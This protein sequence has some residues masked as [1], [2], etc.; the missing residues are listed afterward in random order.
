M[1]PPVDAD[2][3]QL[4]LKK[5]D[6]RRSPTPVIG[7]N[8]FPRRPQNFAGFVKK[9]FR[10]PLPE[11]AVGQPDDRGDRRQ[12]LD[13]LLRRDDEAGSQSRQA[14]FR[15]TERQNRSPPPKNGVEFALV[16]DD[17]RERAA[18]RGVDDQPSAD[19]LRQR[20]Q[21]LQLVSPQD[22]AA[23][24]RRSADENRRDVVFGDRP[25]DRVEVDDVFENLRIIRIRK[26]NFRRTSDEQIG[27]DAHI[28]V[29]DVLGRR[30]NQNFAPP[31]VARSPGQEVQ[32]AKGA[33]LRAADDRD[34]FR[35]YRKSEPLREKSSE[36]VEKRRIA[37]RRVVTNERLVERRG[38]GEKIGGALSPKRLHFRNR[39][40]V[41]APEREQVG[42]ERD[43]FANIVHQIENPA[44]PGKFFAENRQIEPRFRFRAAH[45]SRQIRNIR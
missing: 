10:D 1:Q 7:P 38:V 41:P 6:R 24:V 4:V 13:D 18:V 42:P 35:R 45:F 20:V 12:A 15:Q 3:A 30:R 34:V 22:V 19:S 9:G 39:R 40:R 44:L 27:L 21:P 33:E 26:G 11:R 28:G 8:D 5:R 17:S 37:L 36:R 31:T 29:S 25:L 32:E 23:R 14:D 2:S 43:R 16:L